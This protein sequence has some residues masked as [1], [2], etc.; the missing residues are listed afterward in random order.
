MSLPEEVVTK[1]AVE[2]FNELL[3]VTN[4]YKGQMTSEDQ[5]M[6]SDLEQEIKNIHFESTP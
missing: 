1:I 2:L 4:K 6:V 3:K 5:Q